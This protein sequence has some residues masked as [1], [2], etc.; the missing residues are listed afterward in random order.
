LR[1]APPR[2]SGKKPTHPPP[3]KKKKRSRHPRLARPKIATREARARIQQGGFPPPK[4]NRGNRRPA[5]PAAGPPACFEEPKPAECFFFF[6]FFPVRHRNLGNARS[7]Q[8]AKKQWVPS[9]KSVWPCRQLSLGGSCLKIAPGGGGGADPL[10]R[11]RSNIPLPTFGK[12]RL[13]R[14]LGPAP[15][16]LFSWFLQIGEPTLPYP[17]GPVAVRKSRTATPARSDSRG[18]WTGP[19]PICCRGKPNYRAGIDMKRNG[20]FAAEKPAGPALAESPVKDLLVFS[21]LC[22]NVSPAGKDSTP[23]L[24]RRHNRVWATSRQ[25]FFL[26]GRPRSRP[27]R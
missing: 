5:G 10:P 4:A 23:P 26:P 8:T 13:C 1:K 24:V 7:P 12:T 22:S 20:K 2:G 6:F 19:P 15:L 18:G 9:Q 11:Q 25:V 27:Q 21:H 17:P 3:R 14:K 16:A